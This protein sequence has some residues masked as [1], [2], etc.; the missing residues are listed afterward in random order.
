MDGEKHF[1]QLQLSQSRGLKFG[2][3]G[4]QRLTRKCRKHISKFS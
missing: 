1:I 2:S 3:V 4:T